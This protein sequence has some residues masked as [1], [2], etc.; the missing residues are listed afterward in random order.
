M[1]FD[2]SIDFNETQT[3]LRDT[4]R[5]FSRK[6]LRPRAARIDE[7]GTFGMDTFKEMA[8]LGLTGI[9]IPEEYDGAGADYTSYVITIDELS[10]EC[11]ST[12]LG[13]CAHTSLGTMPI[14]NFGSEELKKKYVP[15]N[16]R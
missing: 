7:E 14:L 4:V 1:L 11:P 16:A 9:P 8:A 5:D 10:R 13:I 12:A 2:A 6:V 15:S 3:L